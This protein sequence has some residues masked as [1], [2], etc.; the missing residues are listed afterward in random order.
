MDTSPK[1]ENA[2][3]IYL[4]NILSQMY[5]TQNKN[6]HDSAPHDHSW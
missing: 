6:K 1:N 5:M 3:T 4:Y 2:F